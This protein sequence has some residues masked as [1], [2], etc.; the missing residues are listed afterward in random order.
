MAEI[1][2]KIPL[3]A[4]SVLI[5]KLR[6]RGNYVTTGNAYATNKAIKVFGFYFCLKAMSSTGV[7]AQYQTQDNEFFKYTTIKSRAVILDRISKCERFGLLKKTG[8][9]N[10]D[11]QLCSWQKCLKIL[12]IETTKQNI[13]FIN[14]DFND[15]VPTPPQYLVE[16]AEEAENQH[17][18]K[19][20]TVRNINQNK[21]LVKLL[22]PLV[23]PNQHPADALFDLQLDSFINDDL[24]AINY[25]LLHSVQSCPFRSVKAMIASRTN[26]KFIRAT[27]ERIAYFKRKINL[28]AIAQVVSNTVTSIGNCRPNLSFFYNGYCTVKNHPKWYLP[29]RLQPMCYVA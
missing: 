9:K 5:T 27:Y 3:K 23:K 25:K 16:L 1:K 15:N 10:K 11:L 17:F 6:K 12:G 7:I 28:T 26:G 19:A 18:T 13:K 29:D 24:T 22:K 8:N 21:E 2:I 4:P 20:A 14:Y